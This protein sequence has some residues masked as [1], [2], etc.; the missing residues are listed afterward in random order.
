MEIK[1]NSGSKRW[2]L[3]NDFIPEHGIE[4]LGYSKEWIDE[5][6]TP[7]GIRLC[8]LNDTKVWTIAAWCGYHDDYHT[9]NSDEPFDEVMINRNPP[10]H[11]R[12]KPE[13]P[14]D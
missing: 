12:Y 1:Q 3:T 7:D 6:Y 9:V 4:V 10:T 14:K 13:P 11:W 5:D 8:F 2:Y